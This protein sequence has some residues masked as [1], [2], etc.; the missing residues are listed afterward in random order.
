MKILEEKTNFTTPLEIIAERYD[1]LIKTNNFKE[2]LIETE[3]Q[4][5]ADDLLKKVESKSEL[6]NEVKK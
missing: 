4:K 3:I 6:I 1:Y 2:P 5:P